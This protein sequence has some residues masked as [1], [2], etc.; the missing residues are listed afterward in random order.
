MTP[1]GKEDPIPI[2]RPTLVDYREVEEAFR[3]VW[4]S[5]LV[6]VGKYT[7]RFEDA[8]KLQLGVKHLNGQP[9]VP[10]RH[11]GFLLPFKAEKTGPLLTG[12]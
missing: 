9:V 10:G 7:A 8:V 12:F 5:G 2:I 4:D 1:S 11:L 3:E 6:T